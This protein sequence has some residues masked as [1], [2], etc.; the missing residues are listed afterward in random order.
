MRRLVKSLVQ[1]ICGIGGYYQLYSIPLRYLRYLDVPEKNC[2]YRPGGIPGSHSIFDL[3]RE[4]N[5]SYRA[6]WYAYGSD[7]D[8]MSQVEN[9]L[10]RGESEF[11]FLYLAGVDA[12]LH[13]HADDSML[14]TNF[15]AGYDAKLRRINEIAQQHFTNVALHVFSDHGMAP[16]LATVDLLA[17]LARID[18]NPTSSGLMLIDS[19]MARF[20]FHSDPVRNAVKA[21]MLDSESG[22]W[23]S[24]AELR[25]AGC[26]VSRSQIR[27]RDLSTFGRASLCP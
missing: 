26:L 21:V 9:D 23:L 2:V 19:T 17:K 20:W 1:R 14:V 27:R 3:L 10:R 6:Y 7:T 25:I 18:L 5:L 12:F 4:R 15:L 24:D 11:Y 13:D 16:T 8:L 22:H